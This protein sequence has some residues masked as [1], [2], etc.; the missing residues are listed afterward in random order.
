MSDRRGKDPSPMVVIGPHTHLRLI[1]VLT[2]RSSKRCRCIKD[3]NRVVKLALRYLKSITKPAHYR[4]IRLLIGDDVRIMRPMPGRLHATEFKPA[5]ISHS[6]TVHR[7]VNQNRRQSLA[8][9]LQNPIHKLSVI[10][11]GK[12]LIVHHNVKAVRP[13]RV[14]IQGNLRV[15]C[16]APLMHHSPLNIGSSANPTRQNSLLSL[17][18]VATPPRDQQRPNRPL[19]PL[20][21]RFLVPL[22]QQLRR[23]AAANQQQTAQNN[24]FL[25][26]KH[27]KT[28][29]LSRWEI[30]V[31]AV[32]N[33]LAGS[34]F[35]IPHSLP[36]PKYPSSKARLTAA[37]CP[38]TRGAKR[39][40]FSPGQPD[41]ITSTSSD[42]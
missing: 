4:V 40:R 15:G 28:G 3:P 37:K 32:G 18:V 8:M 41:S 19:P 31:P 39:S 27:L 30:D 21:R 10:H 1:I 2:T 35:T 17:I 24:G 42:P 9:R 25:H 36:A 26:G 16:R 22:P 14:V 5:V 11:T 34:Q 20:H 29:F 12:T 33:R 6:I 13:V 38:A 23:Q 7:T